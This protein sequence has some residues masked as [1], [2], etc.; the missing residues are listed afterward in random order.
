MD[1][2]IGLNRVLGTVI[3][4]ILGRENNRDSDEAP[5]RRRP[6]TSACRQRKV[7]P[8]VEDVHHVDDATDE[9]FQ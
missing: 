9:V 5:Q 2:T 7:A 1:R 6:T 3:G 4:R 8:I